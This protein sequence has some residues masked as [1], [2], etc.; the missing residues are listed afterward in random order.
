MITKGLDFKDV[1]LVGILNADLALNF[2]SYDA[3]QI[4]FNLIEQASG[5]SG[6]SDK[7]GI[8]I[9][10]SYNPDHYVIQSSKIHDYELFYNKEIKNRYIQN[11]PPFSTYL[12]LTIS[13][14]D[15]KKAFADS[16]IIAN[17][18]KNSAK[19]SKILGPVEDYIFKK[20]DIYNYVINV[21]AKEDSV[22][23]CI[24]ELYPS[25]Q[26][27]KDVNLDIERE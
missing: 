9:I 2:P 20:N 18:L 27:N 25:Y 1:T 24:K 11:M 14:V 10:Q 22:L 21:I 5:R 3:N 15:K 17:A 23:E 12:K 26:S 8:V 7:E 16:I 13:S 4:A 19:E 6:R